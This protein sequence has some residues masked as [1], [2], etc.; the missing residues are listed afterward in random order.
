MK[1]V[2]A[3]TAIAI[4]V[5]AA[6]ILYYYSRKKSKPTK[7][8]VIKKQEELLSTEV[9]KQEGYKYASGL[10]KEYDIV[11]P[12]AHPSKAVREKAEI[13]SQERHQINPKK[14]AYPTFLHEL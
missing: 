9:A 4:A 14:R 5:G 12:H 3:I 6:S 1:S 2:E 8:E 7:P 13:I 10:L 11:I